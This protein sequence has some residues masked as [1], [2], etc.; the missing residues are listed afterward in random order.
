MSTDDTQHAMSTDHQ[1]SQLAKNCKND[2][3]ASPEKL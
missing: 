3:T 1:D 2:T